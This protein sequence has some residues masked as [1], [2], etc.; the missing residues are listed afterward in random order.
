MIT[1][2]LNRDEIT[3]DLHRLLRDVAPDGAL[4]KV[5]G[6]AAA[7]TLKTHFRAR[8]RDANKLGGRRTNFWSRVGESVQNPR[9]RRGGIS[10]AI[11]HPHIAQKVIGGTITPTKA[12]NLAIPIHPDAHGKS[13]RVIEGL[14]FAIRGTTKLLGLT[15]DGRDFTALYV[16]KDSVALDPDP[17]ALP[18]SRVVIAALD[19]AAQVWTRT[20]PTT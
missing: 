2:K 18:E 13:P 4:G 5:L 3:P 6:R 9:A 8:N 14:H 19:R 1:I 20:R 17:K 15:G 11:S 10:I 16:L 12:K 7:N